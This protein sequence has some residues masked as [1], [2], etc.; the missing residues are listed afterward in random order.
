MIKSATI[1]WLDIILYL[2]LTLALNWLHI[3]L[4]LLYNRFGKTVK[5][6]S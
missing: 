1:R 2:H 4:V 5:Q 3:V 6:F